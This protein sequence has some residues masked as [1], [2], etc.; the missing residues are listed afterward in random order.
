MCIY[1]PTVK[2]I[3]FVVV[4]VVVFLLRQFICMIMNFSR[5]GINIIAISNFKFIILFP[6]VSARYNKKEIFCKYNCFCCSGSCI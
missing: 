2:F 4:V 1:A 3:L 5:F 6:S